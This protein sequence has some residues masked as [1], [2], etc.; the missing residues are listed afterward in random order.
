MNNQD[1]LVFG[2]HVYGVY[3]ECDALPKPGETVVG[4]YFDPMNLADGGKGSNQAVCAARL[5]AKTA[6]CGVLGDD[7]P[8]YSALEQ[9]AHANVDTQFCRLS[10]HAHTG[11]SVA[12]LDRHGLSTIVTDMGANR[13]LGTRDVGRMR[14]HFHN[15]R[16][17]LFQFENNVDVTLQAA[18]AAQS[19]GCVAAVTPGPFCP[20]NAGALQGIDVLVPNETEAASLLNID[21][22]QVDGPTDVH[23]IQQ[24]WGVKNVVLTQGAKGCTILW[25]GALL[26]VPAFPVIARNT[27]GAGDGFVAALFTALTWGAD[28]E[29]AAVFASAVS[30]I[31]VCCEG[32][33]WTS[34]PTFEETLVFL[35]QH[36]KE[37]VASALRSKRSLHFL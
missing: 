25:E 26:M 32:A 31:S 34:Y 21:E 20:L 2:S 6:F 13:D 28:I 3:I 14:P 35:Q 37:E 29:D 30:A 33:P 22:G 15:Y 8:A 9:L 5:G 36:D 27:I 23:R 4:R 7:A 12:T 24:Q 10:E 18:R 17:A 11:V 19:E 1:I 16:Y